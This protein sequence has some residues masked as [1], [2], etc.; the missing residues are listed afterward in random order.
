MS[1]SLIMPSMP[2]PMPWVGMAWP[3]GAWVGSFQLV[4]QPVIVSISGPWAALILV[5]RAV[6]SAG[7]SFLASIMSLISTA[8]VW[9]GI[10]IWANMV[11]AVLWSA[12]ASGVLLAGAELEL[13]WFMPGVDVP[14]DPVPVPVEHPASVIAAATAVAERVRSFLFMENQVLQRHQWAQRRPTGGWCIKWMRQARPKRAA[15]RSA[16][17]IRSRRCPVLRPADG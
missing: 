13:P 11:S 7:M 15:G 5:A 3:V 2:P 1:A 14:V 8:W 9:C 4:S 10:I 17:R 12:A 16:R 6:T